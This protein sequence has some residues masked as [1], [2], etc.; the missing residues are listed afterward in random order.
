MKIY[1]VKEGDTLYGIAKENNTTVSRII[2]DNGLAEP[3]RLTVGQSL[4]VLNP[5]LTY[6]VKG[7]DTLYGIAS[8]FGVTTGDLWRNNPSLGGKDVIHPG[9]TLIIIPEEKPY[10]NISV[11]GYAYTFI[12]DDVLEKTLPYLTYLSVFSYGL[13][14]IGQ[15]LPPS[16]DDER[17]IKKAIKYGTIPLLV[18][19]SLTENGTF[20][21]ELAKEVITDSCLSDITAKNAVRKAIEKGYGGIDVDFE[22]I[23]PDASDAYIDF[24]RQIKQEAPED[25]EVFVSLAPKTS[26]SQKGLLYEGH[27]YKGLGE[28]ADKTLVMTYEW[29]YTY[30]PPMPVS[31]IENVKRVLDFAVTEITSDKI[32]MG[33][34]DYAYD[35]TLPYVKGESKAI[36]MS[37]ESALK[38]AKSKNVEI[39]YDEAAE[40]PYFSYY[41]RTDDGTREHVVWFD[42]ARS[43]FSKL[44]LINDYGLSGG[45]VWNVM[46]WFTPL[47]TVLNSLYSI[48]KKQ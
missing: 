31:P 4:I 35:W 22:Y 25:F 45:G 21:S 18:L 36:S 10:G 37:N 48:N 32:F 29:G 42:D 26:S 30:G 1:S 11:N 34:P 19:T 24:I 20:S 41:E 23:E 5:S 46:R 28:V 9:S 7:G 38:L 43:Y 17:L 14:K 33:I 3:S 8:K 47:W 15:L 40:T 13:T 6:T 2:D 39:K 44:K 27:N 12:D 16:N